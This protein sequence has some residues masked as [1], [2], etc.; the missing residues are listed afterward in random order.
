M[1]G[2]TLALVTVFLVVISLSAMIFKNETGNH[3]GL[4]FCGSLR[5]DSVDLCELAD[6]KVSGTLLQVV[7]V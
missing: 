6:T 4:S 1:H 5:L 2:V 3:L 7:L